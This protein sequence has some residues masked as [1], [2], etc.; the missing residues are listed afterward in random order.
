MRK[1]TRSQASEPTQMK[2]KA[3]LSQER[4]HNHTTHKGVFTCLN[5]YKRQV[6]ESQLCS[7]LKTKRCLDRGLSS[8]I[9]D[10][11]LKQRSQRVR[12]EIGS[13][14]NLLKIYGHHLKI[15]MA[16]MASLA[17][18]RQILSKTTTQR[19]TIQE[20]SQASQREPERRANPQKKVRNQFN[21]RHICLMWAEKTT[22]L[23]KAVT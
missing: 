22:R 14:R 7:R 2:G 6:S 8:S 4:S 5:Q 20:T 19:R 21:K 10:I 23:A 16:K 12:G 11:W 17:S 18:S 9:L 1:L 15:M 13:L 3:F